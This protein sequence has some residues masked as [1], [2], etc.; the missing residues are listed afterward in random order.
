MFQYLCVFFPSFCR[1]FLSPSSPGDGAAHQTGDPRRWENEL[2][3][4]AEP[5]R[6]GL[7]SLHQPLGA[8]VLGWRGV[9]FFSELR[10]GGFLK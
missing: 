9:L 4:D 3:L 2:G 7:R 6:F 8:A 10:N 5:Q 1:F